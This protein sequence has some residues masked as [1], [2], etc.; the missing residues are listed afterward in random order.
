MTKSHY[1][2]GSYIV[3]YLLYFGL[4]KRIV[5]FPVKPLQLFIFNFCS[6][7][8]YTV[9]PNTPKKTS[10]TRLHSKQRKL[11]ARGDKKES[12]K[13]SQSNVQ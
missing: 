1:I 12:V 10:G 3:K 13:G 6:F 4:S 9:M 7:E 2:Y 11:N 8:K 5:I